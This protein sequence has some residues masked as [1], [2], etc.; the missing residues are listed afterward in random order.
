MLR[1]LLRILGFTLVGRFLARI[2]DR[3]V[4]PVAFG[5][6]LLANLL[7]LVALSTGGLGVGDVLGWLWLEVL[8]IFV[9]GT[10]QRA[11]AGQTLTFWVVHYGLFFVGGS[12][13]V[14]LLMALTDFPIGQEWW[15]FGVLALASFLAAGYAQ[16][17]RIL[18]RSAMSGRDFVVAY[19]RLAVVFAAPFALLLLVPGVD[20]G[21]SRPVDQDTARTVAAGVL[22]V[23]LVLEAGV[24][25]WY[26]R[27]SAWADPVGGRHARS[28]VAD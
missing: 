24:F 20:Q 4:A 6:V 2:P 13:P 19:L 21:D 10:V 26:L 5:L 7:P 15:R 9:W 16:R 8:S 14:Y 18:R 11:R 12:L 3:Y 1:S 27:P 23:K 28:V 25:G 22:L 17:G